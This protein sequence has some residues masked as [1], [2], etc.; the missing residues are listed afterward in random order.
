[1]P[2]IFAT[3]FLRQLASFQSKT[4]RSSK[5]DGKLDQTH[6]REAAPVRRLPTAQVQHAVSVLCD[7]FHDYPVMRYVIGPGDG[8][9]DRRLHTLVNFFVM[10]RVWREEPILGI[11]DGEELVAAATL[12]LPG[13]RQ[14][15]AEF[16]RLRASVWRE[17]GEAARQRYE[18]FSAATQAFDP[19]RPHH[20]LSMIGV[21]Q[22]HLGRG[23]A[24]QLL[25]AVHA[26]SEED[27][28]SQGVALTT[29]NAR[30][31]SLYEHFGYRVVGHARVAAR[32]E[33]WGFFRPRGETEGRRSAPRGK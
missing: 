11:S 12:T 31:V 28:A 2:R 4:S 5:I 13:K 3:Q 6:R 21:R 29:E 25:A 7:A 9:Y 30:N 15:P 27:P 19:G 17:L 1:M 18:A 26:M 20:H 24:R 33:T 16:A 10:A 23:L 8:D 14:P 22:S 32:L